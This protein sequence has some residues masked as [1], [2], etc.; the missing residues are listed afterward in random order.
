MD[1]KTVGNVLKDD[2]GKTT[3]SGEIPQPE[4]TVRNVRKNAH[5]SENAHPEDSFYW[6]K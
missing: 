1:Q 2:L 4:S 5:V 3:G 6:A